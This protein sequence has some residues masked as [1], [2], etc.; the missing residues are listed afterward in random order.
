[1][2]ISNKY[3]IRNKILI[4]PDMF[5]SE[6]FNCLSASA[7]KTL[8]RFLQKRKWETKK[9][10]GKKQTIYS[11]VGFIFPYSEAT[12]L[13]IAG[14]TQHWKNLKKLIEAGFLDLVHQGGWYQ[15]HEREKD[16]SV[17]KISERWRKYGTP[18]FVTVE[19]P[20]VLREQFHIRENMKRQKLKVTSQKRSG[21]FH[22]SEDDNAISE[23][24]RLHKSEVEEQ[25]MKSHQSFT[26]IA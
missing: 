1:M 3:K 26:A 7:I 17:Y 21:Q 10:R 20:K 19:K 12:A 11:D 8:M 23:N 25:A 2:E 16:Y 24:G 6:A 9:N 4:E 18:E 22:K 15:K 5:Y 14:D 13:K